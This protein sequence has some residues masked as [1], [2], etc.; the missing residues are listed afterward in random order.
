MNPEDTLSFAQLVFSVDAYLKAEGLEVVNTHWEGE[1]AD[2]GY[3]VLTVKRVIAP[4]LE[5]CGFCEH[6][7]A[8][9]EADA[10]GKGACLAIDC[11]CE[12]YMPPLEVPGD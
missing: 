1:T 7:E 5:P 12:V 4:P 11:A 8:V 6:A 9:H 2:G 10:A 3:L